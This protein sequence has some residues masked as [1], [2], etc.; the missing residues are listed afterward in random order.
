MMK[1]FQKRS[2]AIL[3][4]I[5]VILL[6][7]YIGAGRSLNKAAH[8]VEQLFYDGVY[9]SAEKYT[10]PGIYNHLDN[11][12]DCALGLITCA[13]ELPELSEQTEALRQSR[14]A[15]LDAMES[16][17]IP[18]MYSANLALQSDFASLS[19][20][21][22]SSGNSSEQ[23]ANYISNFE[24]AQISIQNDG[25]NQAVQSYRQI[26]LR[27]FPANILKVVTAAD[28]PDYFGIEG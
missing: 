9:N 6:F 3:V 14:I 21:Y 11:C 25:Y 19:A 28:T 2:A 24:G 18:A 16:R 20:A 10:A 23:A 7:S 15:L 13:S 4:L 8:N 26:T 12:T 5:V 1:F 27:A 17:N 22:S